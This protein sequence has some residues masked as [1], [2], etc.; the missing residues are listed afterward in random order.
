LYELFSRFTS[1]SLFDYGLSDPALN[2]HERK[3]SSEWSTK[4]IKRSGRTTEVVAAIMD[5]ALWLF[6]LNG[7]NKPIDINIGNDNEIFCPHEREKAYV[8]AN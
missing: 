3:C 7:L 2:I 1:L 6:F 5:Y 8:N 4:T